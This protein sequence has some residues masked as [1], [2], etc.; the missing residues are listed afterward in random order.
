MLTQAALAAIRGY[1]RHVSPRKGYG[2]AYR[3]AHGGTGCSGFAKTAIAERGLI[4]ALP[5]IR[6]RQRDCRAAAVQLSAERDA[7]RRG[8]WY[9]GLEN[10]SCDGSGCDASDC[11]H[12]A[13]CD[14]QP[15][16][17]HL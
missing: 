8:R 3:L 1:Q 17:C 5:S 6:T 13:A 7:K 16:C 14:C 15:D 11:H 9:D 2:C 4:R 10:C 12:L